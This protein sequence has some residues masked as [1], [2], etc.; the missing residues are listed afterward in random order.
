MDEV[1]DTLA[2]LHMEISMTSAS[3]ISGLQPSL[4]LMT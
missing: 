2:E 3:S 4:A 1:E